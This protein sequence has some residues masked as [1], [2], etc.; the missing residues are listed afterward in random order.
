MSF[1]SR[2]TA[3]R[4]IRCA[5]LRCDC[6]FCLE[7]E[8]ELLPPPLWV[9]VV[10]AASAT[11]AVVIRTTIIGRA[12]ENRQR[13]IFIDSPDGKLM[14]RTQSCFVILRSRHIV[15]KHSL[16]GRHCPIAACHISC[17]QLNGYRALR[18]VRCSPLT[19]SA[20][21]ICLTSSIRFYSLID[22]TCRI[23]I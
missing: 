14:L 23:A 12:N 7:S 1:V 6:P 22:F 2:L 9:W 10:T 4:W 17:A 5:S 19:E 18:C 8:G 16:I 3:S 11:T 21:A 13:A 15:A 20:S